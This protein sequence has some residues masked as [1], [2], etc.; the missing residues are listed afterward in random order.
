[1]INEE[2]IRKRVAREILSIIEKICFSDEFKEYRINQGS[3]GER[4]LII[5]LI[6]E[7]YEVG[8][9]DKSRVSRKLFQYEFN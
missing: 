1:M 7:R 9:V 4:D 2:I 3:N 6:K 5:K 8:W